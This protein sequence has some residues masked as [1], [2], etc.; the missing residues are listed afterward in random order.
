[1]YHECM[2]D[3]VKP[4]REQTRSV[5]RSL[6]AR[7]ALEVFTQKGYDNATVDEIAAA[8]GV[9]RRTLFNY[10]G[11]KE[12]LALSGLAEQGEVIAARLAEQPVDEDIWVSLHE[13]FRVLDEI[14][15]A[16]ESRLKVTRLVFENDTLRAGHAEKHARWE[17]VLVPEIARRLPT[18]DRPVFDARAIAGAAISC[19]QAATEEWVRLGGRIELLCLYDDA[20][21]A[22]RRPT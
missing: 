1:M 3:G 21:E 17:A 16:P 6:L 18:S 7:T 11:S 2:A 8:A 10:F 13:A 20:V 22:V 9:S 12:E 19:L 15:V 5:V 4:I 14:E